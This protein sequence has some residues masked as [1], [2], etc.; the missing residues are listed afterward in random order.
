MKKFFVLS[1][2][3]CLSVEVFFAQN[4]FK[5]AYYITS[6]LDTISGFIRDDDWLNSPNYFNFKKNLNEEAQKIIPQEVVLFA[7]EGISTYIS[8]EVQ[9]DV[10]PSA[11]NKLT[12]EAAPI[13]ETRHVFL[14][15]LV[16]GK[17]N[18]Y[19]YSESTFVKYFIQVDDG[20]L[21]HLMYKQFLTDNGKIG[22]NNQFRQQLFSRLS[23]DGNSEKDFQRVKYKQKELIRM[24][25][26]YNACFSNDKPEI[27]TYNKRKSSF[28]RIRPGLQLATFVSDYTSTVLSRREKFDSQVGFRIGLEYEY[29]FGFNNNKWAFIVEPS[30][31]YYSSSAD[32]TSFDFA[33][34]F[35]EIDYASIE[36]QFGIRYYMFIHPGHS[37][38]SNIGIVQDFVLRGEITGNIGNDLDSFSSTNNLFLGVGY[39][40]NRR[41]NLELRLHTGRNLTQKYRSDSN[42]TTVGLIFGYQ[43][44]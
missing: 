25:E 27:I 4:T 19:R 40:F 35:R 17:A 10:T 23:C 15:Q 31:Q 1:L 5:N 21:T 20:E 32:V 16:G 8:S 37:I 36:G 34:R 14:K 38:F 11:V 3:L 12:K 22:E 42:Y 7:I 43:F 26:V 28:L 33:P 30:F 39:Q 24:V 13:W 41:L 29:V 18:L 44:L 9:M 2:L 6:D